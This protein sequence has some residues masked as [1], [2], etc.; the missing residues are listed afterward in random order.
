MARPLNP[1]ITGASQ[2]VFLFGHP[3]HHS[4]SPDMHNAAF[5]KLGLPW[6]YVPLELGPRQPEFA[7]SLMRGSNVRGANVTVPYKEAFLPYLDWIAPESKWLGSVNTLFLKGNKLCGTSTDGGGFLKSIGP[8]RK[9]LQGSRG[10]LLGSGGAAKAVAGALAQSGV[11]GFYVTDLI[12]A[13]A[14]GLA[15]LIRK[16]YRRTEVDVVSAGETHKFLPRCEWVV[17]ATSC[18]LKKGDPSPL[19]LAQARPGT[20]VMDLIYHHETAFLKEAKQRRLPCFGGLSMLLHQGV[21]SYEIWTGRK[22]PVEVMRRTLL[23][24]LHCR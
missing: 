13:R 14:E 23:R 11:K 20:W 17:Q 16:R 18:G 4:L 10:L 15:R 22:A 9:K 5:E 1:H 12:F 21:L 24:Q 3:L 7:A 6:V 2:V 19:S 8:R